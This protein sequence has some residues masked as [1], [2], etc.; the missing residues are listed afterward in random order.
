MDFTQRENTSLLNRM[1]G[2]YALELYFDSYRG[3]LCLMR[4][5]FGVVFSLDLNFKGR[6]K[7]AL[8][9]CKHRVNVHLMSEVKNLKEL[10]PRKNC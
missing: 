3:F 9:T 2:P 7:S 8:F 1:L 4:R 6:N 5:I 10:N